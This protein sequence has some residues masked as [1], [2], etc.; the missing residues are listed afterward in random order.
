MGLI[1]NIYKKGFLLVDF[2]MKLKWV[3]GYLDLKYLFIFFFEDVGKI[4]S[5]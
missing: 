3:I 4:F 5:N 1:N 2:S